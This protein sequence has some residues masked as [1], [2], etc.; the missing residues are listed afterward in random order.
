MKLLE[1]FGRALFFS[2]FSAIGIFAVALAVLGPEWENL[3]KIN[4]ATE[5]MQQDN[6]QIEQ[7]IED[8]DVLIGKIHKDP[9]MLKR[10][11]PEITSEKIEDAN[12]PDVQITAEMLE[13][14]KAAIEQVDSNENTKI[15]EEVPA[16]LERTTLKSSRIILFA[17]GAGL[18]LVSFVCFNAKKEKTLGDKSS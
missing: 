18:V 10:L 8:H 1:T 16:W 13:Q 4:A 11:A 7:I 14:A 2:L 9:N 6:R 17:A 12:L 3:Y 5:K 15:S